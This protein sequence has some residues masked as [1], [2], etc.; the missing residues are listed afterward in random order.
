MTV[1]CL[2]RMDAADGRPRRR[3]DRPGNGRVTVMSE[4]NNI[5]LFATGSCEGLAD[6]LSALQA[7]E[8]LELVGSQETVAEAAA[9]LSGGHLDAVLH[10][11]RGAESPAGDLAAIREYTRAPI[12]ML[13]SGESS[14]LLEEALEADR[15]STRLNSSHTVISYAVFC[16]KKK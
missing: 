11:T 1:E 10:A 13:S 7:H 12:I 6:I 5:R 14:G 8:G 15:K 16:L 9:A 3:K 4:Q 2:D